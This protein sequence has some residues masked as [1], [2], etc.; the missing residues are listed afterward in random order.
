MATYLPYCD[1]YGADRLMAEVARSLKVPEH[2]N[3]HLFDSRK[4]GVTKLIDHL[5]NAL[6]S[7]ALVN[8][9]GLS[10]F[11]AAT[12]SIKEN[13]FSFFRKIGTRR[14]W[15]RTAA[16]SG[17]SCSALDHGRMPRYEMGQAPGVAAPI[18]GLQDVL[19][20]K[21]GASDGTRRVRRRRQEGMPLHH[22]VLVDAYQDL[23]DDFIMQALATPRDASAAC[24][25]TGSTVEIAG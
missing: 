9:P 24:W 22:F 10:I 7:I 14:R 23:R 17:S 19:V 21:C 8:V 1:V 3:C 20:I 13:S 12:D 18:Y 16:A 5:R 25:A 2:Y 6:A 11:V 4:D 15:L